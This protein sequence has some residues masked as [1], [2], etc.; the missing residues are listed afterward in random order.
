MIWSASNVFC[1]KLFNIL[2]ILT[3]IHHKFSSKHSWSLIFFE[4]GKLFFL[5]GVEEE[6][7]YNVVEPREE[8]VGVV[9]DKTVDFEG[10]VV[11]AAGAVVGRRGGFCCNCFC[12]CNSTTAGLNLVFW[13]KNLSTRVFISSFTN[14]LDPIGTRC[15]GAHGRFH[16]F[17]GS[18]WSCC[19]FR[20]LE[21]TKKNWNTTK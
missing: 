14:L 7:A 10:V 2:I 15:C 9:V 16:K 19:S 8:I 4:I 12:C 13:F 17:L 3:F 6:V 18:R 21:K 1:S 11:V 5:W 20:L